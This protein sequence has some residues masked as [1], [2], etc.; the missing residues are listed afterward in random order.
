MSTVSIRSAEGALNSPAN[1]PVMR[2]G[3]ERETGSVASSVTLR[4]VP[5]EV[6]RAVPDFGEP[7]RFA[8]TLNARQLN[9]A[10]DYLF[11]LDNFDSDLPVIKEVRESNT[12]DLA[13][14]EQI[15][16]WSLGTPKD[17][18]ERATRSFLESSYSSHVI[19]P[20]PSRK[21]IWAVLLFLAFTIPVVGAFAAG[22]PP[23]AMLAS[24]GAGAL[25][26]RLLAAPPRIQGAPL[27]ADADWQM[28][29]NDVVDSVL[30]SILERRSAITTE[31]AAALRR[32]F[33]HIRFIS[34]TTAAMATPPYVPA[35]PLQAAA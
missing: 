3:V 32:G 27:V 24:G 10:L 12:W 31:Q 17:F 29:Y 1:V 7:A 4:V 6:S 18:A 5:T 19:K 22:F 23:L 9:V 13:S 15:T 11:R 33:D 25:I 34:H 21:R 2:T 35:A 30:A 14:A 16:R 26:F 8:K 20:S 28:L